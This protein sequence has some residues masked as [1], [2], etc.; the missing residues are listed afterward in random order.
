M[1]INT[2][3]T[4]FNE[5]RNT[6][7]RM[8]IEGKN[9]LNFFIVNVNLPGFQLGT[10]EQRTPVGSIPW[11]GDHQFEELQV[12]FIV[13]EDLT[14]WKQ[15]FDWMRLASTVSDYDEYDRNEIFRDGT[16]IL[17]TNSRSPK[18][19]IIFRGLVPRTLSGIDFDTRASDPEIIVATVTFAYVEYT[20]EEVQ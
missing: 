3:P 8:K 2:Q 18:Q 5:L 11:S 13:D 12:Q 4:N 1:G 14:N 7:F 9:A 10:V 15:V 20:I 16:L 17:T 6:S 19:S